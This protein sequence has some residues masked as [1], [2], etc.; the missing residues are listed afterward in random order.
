MAVKRKRK[1]QRTTEKVQAKPDSAKGY[2]ESKFR[3]VVGC[4]R[5]RIYLESREMQG[6]KEVQKRLQPLSC[7]HSCSFL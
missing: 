1:C 6:C 2:I 5:F 3:T 4:I 7:H